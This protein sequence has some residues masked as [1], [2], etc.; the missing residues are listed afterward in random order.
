[1]PNNERRISSV[2]NSLDGRRK[3]RSYRAETCSRNEARRRQFNYLKRAQFFLCFFYSIAVLMISPLRKKI[4]VRLLQSVSN[5]KLPYWEIKYSMMQ[6]AKW[7]G[8]TTQKKP[9]YWHFILF[10]LIVIYFSTPHFASFH[11]TLRWISLLG[12]LMRFQQRESIPKEW[13]SCADF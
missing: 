8:A 3:L 6:S 1:M 4:R 12:Y 11:L 13:I 10:L 9:L 2:F 5:E 7:I